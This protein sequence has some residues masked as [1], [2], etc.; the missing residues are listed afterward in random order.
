[1]PASTICRSRPPSASTFG[2]WDG[3]LTITPDWTIWGCKL[4]DRNLPSDL[5]HAVTRQP[6]EVAHVQRVPGHRRIQL[7][8]PRP[9]AR[10]VFGTNDRFMTDVVGDIIKLQRTAERGC[11]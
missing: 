2:R 7:F 5:D 11:L 4:S 3:G 10:T 6:Q 1:M 9:H 8:L